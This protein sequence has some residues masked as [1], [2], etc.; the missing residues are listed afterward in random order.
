MVRSTIIVRAIDALPLAASVD[1]EKVRCTLLMNISFLNAYV[2]YYTADGE[3]PSGAQTASKSN[4]STHYAQCRTPLFDWEWPIYSTVRPSKVSSG[5]FLSVDFL[6]Q[7]PYLGQCCILDYSW[8][9]VSAETRFL[10]SWWTLEG[11]CIDLRF[12]DWRCSKTLCLCRLRY[13]ADRYERSRH[14]LWNR[15]FHGKDCTTVPGY[16]DS[17][18][19]GVWTRQA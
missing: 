16:T 7:L 19:C 12:K 4:I 3:R 15:H 1:D 6:I 2:S 5:L 18:C 9:V 11:I 14:W 10:V 13:V 8:Q 17:K